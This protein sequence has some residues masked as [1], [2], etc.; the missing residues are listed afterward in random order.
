MYR[1]VQKQF[2]QLNDGS[3]TEVSAPSRDFATELAK[4]STQPGCNDPPSI[5]RLADRLSSVMSDHPQSVCRLSAADLRSCEKI[6]DT[7]QPKNLPDILRNFRITV[8]LRAQSVN[9]DP[10]YADQLAFLCLHDILRGKYLQVYNELRLGQIN[11]KAEKP[12]QC[13]VSTQNTYD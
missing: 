9:S 11:W 4:Q 10:S 5:N 7:T 6:T 2:D 3:I 12:S 1:F 13:P 8:G